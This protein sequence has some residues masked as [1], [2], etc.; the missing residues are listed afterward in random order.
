MLPPPPLD[1]ELAPAIEALPP[2]V[3]REDT[4]ATLRQQPRPPVPLSDSVRRTDHVVAA[5]PAVAVR[6]HRAVGAEGRLPCIVSMHGGGLVLGSHTADDA[7]FDEWCPALGVVGVAV[8]YRLAPEARYPGALED[9]YAALRWAHDE[10][11]ALGIDRARIG[12]RGISAGAGLAAAVALLA[13]ERGAVDVAF[14]L[15]DAPML[16]DRQVT[17]SSRQDGLAVWT[18]EAN[19]FGWRAYLGEL[20]GTDGVPPTAAP[21]RATDLSGLPPAFVSVGTADGFRDEAIDYA[22]RLNQAGVPCE[23]HVYAGAPHGY[24][25]AGETSIAR[26]AKQDTAAWL[27][28]AIAAPATARGDARSTT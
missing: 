28:R 20:C 15:L 21:A 5:D 12:L 4:L 14:Q 9:G 24:H 23:L 13:R 25:L 10:A 22:L 8:D 3:L 11:D 7:L 27:A 2:V 1:P 19:A 6:V 17:P 26:R 18:R 16:D